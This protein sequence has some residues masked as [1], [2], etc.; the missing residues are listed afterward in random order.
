MRLPFVHQIMRGCVKMTQYSL[1][2]G[3]VDVQTRF[4]PNQVIGGSHLPFKGPLRPEAFLLGSGGAGD[5]DC[6]I[7]LRFGP[8]LE[9]ERD[10]HHG[11]R[12][13]LCPPSLD[14]SAPQQPDSR[15][16]YAFEPLAG[17]RVGEH[18]AS[19]FIAAQLTVR[20]EDFS[21]EDRSNLSEGGLAGLNDLPC[22]VVG[23]HHR[24]PA[25][26]E[27]LGRSGLAHANAAR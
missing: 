6:A 13:A 27:D 22:Q 8:G 24:N 3:G 1:D 11:E 18:A 2:L 21:A 5:A 9:Q 26:A 16:Q 25:I 12:M 19:Q 4:G 15:V 23:V 20:P 7:E 10:H 14:L 17:S